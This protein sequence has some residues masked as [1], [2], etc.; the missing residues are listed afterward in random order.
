MINQSM[1]E[2]SNEIISLSNTIRLVEQEMRSQDIP[3]LKVDNMTVVSG[4][5]NNKSLQF[6]NQKWSY[7]HMH[8]TWWKLFSPIVFSELQGNNKE[9]C[10]IA[11]SMIKL[12]FF[13][14]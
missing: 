7:I 6:L 8:I 10:V 11:T 4:N 12:S 13:L 3:F 2:M 5:S 14:G 9:V 1:E